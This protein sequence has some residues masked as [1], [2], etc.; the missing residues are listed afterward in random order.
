MQ[1]SMTY[2]EKTSFEDLTE[3]MESLNIYFIIKLVGYDN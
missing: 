2:G 3:M 1:L